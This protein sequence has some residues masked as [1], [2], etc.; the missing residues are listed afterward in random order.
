MMVRQSFCSCSTF[1]K[2]RV[3]WLIVTLGDLARKSPEAWH[4]CMRPQIGLISFPSFQS[5]SHFQPLP[6]AHGE[7]KRGTALS[8]SPLIYPHF[9]LET[10]SP[11]RRGRCRRRS[12]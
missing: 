5:L 2:F 6:A 12:C 10:S 9:L 8:F 11:S 1:T 3:C 4:T 7:D